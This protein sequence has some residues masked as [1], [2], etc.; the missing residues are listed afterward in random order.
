MA[1]VRII[2]YQPCVV[3]RA[4]CAKWICCP[5][6]Y[7][8]R[9]VFVFR[10]IVPACQH[11]NTLELTDFMFQH[12]PSFILLLI[13]AGPWF[14]LCSKRFFFSFLCFIQRCMQWKLERVHI[15]ALTLYAKSSTQRKYTMH[16]VCTRVSCVCAWFCVIHN[17]CYRSWSGAFSLSLF[18]AEPHCRKGKF[19]QF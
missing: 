10:Y 16:T 8:Y 11:V 9:I 6:T 17:P 14:S 19:H 2:W 7:V 4:P 18:W 12:L 1:S 13:Y 15:L 5:Q 3:L